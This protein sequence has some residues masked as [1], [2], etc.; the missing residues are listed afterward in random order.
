MDRSFCILTCYYSLLLV[1]VKDKTK[2]KLKKKLKKGLDGLKEAARLWYD[3]LSDDLEK[4]DGQKLTGDPGC[5]S[6]G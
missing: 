4:H 5:Q 2:R 6:L 1:H 3:E